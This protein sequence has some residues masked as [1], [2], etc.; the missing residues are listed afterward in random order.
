MVTPEETPSRYPQA[1]LMRAD[2]LSVVLTWT[3]LALAALSW[4]AHLAGV[5]GFD[6]ATQLAIGAFILG[7]GVHIVLALLHRR[8]GCG[9]H[10]TIQGFRRPHTVSVGQ[11]R[12]ERWAGVV[13]SVLRRKRF[14]CIHCGV[15]H[16]V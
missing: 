1:R 12:A 9:K 15:E 3:M 10:P 8:P 4:I 2:A 13:V 11:S 5:D 14:V 16:L 7:L 6:M